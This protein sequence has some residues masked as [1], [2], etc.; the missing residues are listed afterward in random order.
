MRMLVAALA[1][2]SGLA[3]AT[4]STT[5][6]T[7]LWY[8]SNEEGWGANVIHQR[9]TLFITLFVYGTNQQPT[10][11]VASDVRLVSTS[12][13]VFTYNGILYRTT[14]PWFGAGSFNE[15]NVTVTPV[16]TITF[17]AGQVNQASLT[18]TVEGLQVSKTVTRQTWSQEDLSGSYIG[19]TIG[20][21]SNCPSN[22]NGYT[23]DP[24]T[25]TVNHSGTTVSVREDGNGYSCTY[26]GTYTQ[27]G[28]MG[29]V[30][31]NGACTDGVNQSFVMSEVT[32]SVNSLTMRFTA[33]VG[34]C[35]FVGRMGGMR[36]G[37]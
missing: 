15:A 29:T 37:S 17:L 23:E 21:W 31:G 30:T 4:S 16:G 34:A 35:T 7:D 25:L 10:W 14:G 12:N 32:P 5:D 6:F 20:T 1:F 8:N 3:C 28:R 27:A 11:Y 19:A 13:G 24:V 9:D 22:R 18:Y 2:C 33:A 26:T 36:R